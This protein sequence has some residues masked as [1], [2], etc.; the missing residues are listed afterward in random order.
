ME[1]RD[2]EPQ[3]ARPYADPAVSRDRDVVP[4][5]EPGAEPP[6]PGAEPSGP[7]TPDAQGMPDAPGAVPVPSAAD[8]AGASA[9]TST[10]TSAEAS[11]EASTKMP[12]R[13]SAGASSAQAPPAPDGE[14][15]P[16]H[17]RARR[18]L[19]LLRDRLHEEMA[20]L[21]ERVPEVNGSVACSVDGLPIASDLRGET[22]QIGALSSAV[23]A[24]SGRLTAMAEKGSFEETLISGSNGYAVF[25]AAGPTI[26][27]T[28]LA[29]PGT[30]LGLLRLEGRK[31]AARLA[32]IT[33]RTSTTH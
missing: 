25:Y 15:V 19:A 28:V 29:R 32:A 33:S 18:E 1:A 26:V 23:L 12:T 31:T 9:G 5:R 11:T 30:N 2:R 21:R 20:L 22:E 4:F 6:G 8:G 10:E 7:G 17:D 14:G 27:L 13:T 16:L 24:L 3:G